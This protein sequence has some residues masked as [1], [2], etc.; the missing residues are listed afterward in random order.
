MNGQ[1]ETRRRGY[2]SSKISSMMS[3]L[4]LIFSDDISVLVKILEK[5]NI[6]LMIDLLNGIQNWD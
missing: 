5:N 6:T 3:E 2:T 1:G 4:W